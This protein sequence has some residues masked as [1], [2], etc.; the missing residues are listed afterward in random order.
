MQN[1]IIIYSKMHQFASFKKIGGGHVREP[2][3]SA[4][5]LPHLNTSWNPPPPLANPAY[6]CTR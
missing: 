4:C 2:L 1:F 3:T 6:A 5:N